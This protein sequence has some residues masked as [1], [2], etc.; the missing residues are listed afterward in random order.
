MM[1]RAS[2]LVGREDELGILRNTL[3]AASA[4][5]G[6]AVFIVGESG[7][8]KSRLIAAA[9][10]MGASAGTT[11]LRGRG[12]SIGPS[13]PFRP[14]TEA[15]L[16]LPRGEG[17]SVEE[18][19][20]YRP[21]LGRLVPD[22]GTPPPGSD[23]GSL[24]LLA[25]AVLRLT[26][27]AGRQRGCLLTLDDMQDCDIETLALV[28]YLADNIGRQPTMLI[29][30]IRDDPCP[31]LDLAHAAA[32][33]RDGVLIELDRLDVT[34]VRTL[35]ASCLTAD[36]RDIPDELVDQLWE[37]SEGI[38]LLAEE[39]LSTMLRDRLLTAEGGKWRVHGKLRT[40]APAALTRSVGSQLDAA[41][42]QARE[43]V[44]IAAVLGRRFP[45]TLMLQI[46]GMSGH[47]LHEYLRSDRLAQFIAPD[48]QT[49]DWYAF[50]HPL[51]V[52]AVLS[53]LSPDERAALTR[54]AAAGVEAANPGLPGEWCQVSATLHAQAGDLARA[55]QLFH[56][57]GRRA[58]A[59]GAANSA[60]ALL[61]RAIEL[62]A[63]DQ[64]AQQRADAF[65]TLLHALAEAGMVER[66]VALA[67]DI[68]NV[69]GTLSRRSRADLHT[70]LAWAAAV[71]GRT[72]VGLAQV[73]MARRL[74]GPDPA[75]R[76]IAQVDV[77]EAHLV[78]DLPGSG[79]L[80]AAE[81][82]AR[83]AAAV[84]DEASLP[85]VSCQAW[86]LLGALTRSRDPGEAS[87]CLERALRLA[88][89][90]N[91]PIE[92]IHALIRLGRDDALRDGSL[93]RLEQAH[94]EATAVGAVTSRYQAEVNMALQ[95]ILRAD[96]GTAEEL[97]SQVLASTTR[98][99][100]LET[101]RQALVL[102]AVLA[103][104]RGRRGDMEAALIKLRLGDGDAAPHTP[105]IYGLARAWCALL[106]ENRPRALRELSLAI[107]AEDQNPTIYPLSGRYGVNLLLRV[108]GGAADEKEYQ[109][110]TSVPLSQLR[111]D[112]QFAL[113]AR[114][115]LS[116]RAGDQP[117]AVSA[118]AEAQELGAIFPT[119]HHLGLRLVSE[120]AIA[121]R[122]GTPIPWLRVAEE[123]FYALG[124]PAVASAC[125]ALLRQAGA[126]VAQRR[127]GVQLIPAVL[128]A[129]GVTAREYE[130]LRLLA[131]RLTNREIGMRLH[132]SPRTIEKHVASLL[133]KTGRKDR[134]ALAEFAL[135]TLSQHR[136]QAD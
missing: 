16:C 115:V 53:L 6:G 79:Q 80:Q 68:G 109:A 104:H 38:P 46:S 28:E 24:V 96:F 113:L 60:V 8:G 42:T 32:R 74:L 49:A 112:R 31:A 59:L 85:V 10:S 41:G 2:H 20:P 99:K 90:H 5:R 126:G 34:Q 43:L 119:A 77:V 102:R 107:T 95:A 114:A 123:H 110:V 62:L 65:A 39:L 134:I 100:L 106:E 66:A 55:G 26:G 15:L 108:L 64:E 35:A 4:G 54:R 125:R 30:T 132:A 129:V 86:Q 33:D 122:W 124:A 21:V 87:A 72:S 131:E 50:R 75:D 127:G 81:A 71:A 136:E 120:A 83:R 23:G 17:V 12:S 76:D 57:A 116:G 133:A 98:L 7:I 52:D 91:L 27:L 82:L 25:E 14:V 97:L 128:R 111:W 47:D 130:V 84:A 105:R 48:E 117:A 29:G 40:K 22:W 94:R 56:E 51:L 121:D 61:D 1:A 63:P 69:T 93:D 73:E 19:G 44:A 101:T 67:D 18:L 3:Q 13:V 58:L 78:L 70:R 36:E 92:V 37:A 9:A 135:T 118:V 88:Q 11:V 89:Q 103:A 45:F